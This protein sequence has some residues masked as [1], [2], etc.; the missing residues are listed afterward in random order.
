[1]QLAHGRGET[2][3]D[4]ETDGVGPYA[5]LPL[6]RAAVSLDAAYSA[7]SGRAYAAPSRN[8]RKSASDACFWGCLFLDCL[9]A[10]PSP[11]PQRSFRSVHAAARC[12]ETSAAV[13]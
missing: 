10:R 13:S 6:I 1:M 8:T 5:V 7:G 3:E 11:V 12:R 2:S 9:I 4:N